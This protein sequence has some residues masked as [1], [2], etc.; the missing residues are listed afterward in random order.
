[1]PNSRYDHSCGTVSD[2]E[3]G[4]VVVV[5]G[6]RRTEDSYLDTVDFYAVDTGSWS[7]GSKIYFRAIIWDNTLEK[8]N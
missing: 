6:G 5:A 4:P 2:P 3:L 8:S 1:M 7:S